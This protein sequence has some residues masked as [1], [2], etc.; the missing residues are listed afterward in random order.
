M[1]LVRGREPY[2]LQGAKERID[3]ESELMV[4]A[5]ARRVE[6]LGL[7]DRQVAQPSIIDIETPL[8]LSG[9]YGDAV[10]PENVSRAVETSLDEGETHYTV[11]PGL[12]ALARA[13]A[14]KLAR[15]QDFVVDPVAEVAITCGGREGMFIALQALTEPGR[16]V[17]VPGLR[18]AFID[19]AVRLT[20][21][22]PVPVP[23]LAQE[24]LELHA[25]RIRECLTDD[26]QLLVV[27]NPSDPTGTVIPA[28]KLAHIAALAQ[29]RDLVIISDE[30]LDESLAGDVR[31][32]SI[33]SFP[34]S[35]RRT[36]V[37]GS[38]SRLHSL[39]SW[40][41][42]YLA[43]PKS[44][45]APVRTLKLAMTLCTS[46]MAQY[47]A[48]E[49][50]AGP[51]DWLQRRRAELDAKRAFVLSA[52]EEMGLAH[53]QPVVSP[54]VLVDVRCTGRSSREFVAWLH[55]EAQVL[56]ASGDR[57]G[58]QGEGYVRLSLWPNFSKLEQAMRRIKALL[59]RTGGDVS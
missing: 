3:L 44:L 49:A 47:A 25:D 5:I 18:S 26:A 58:E 33:A 57:F 38:F 8:D 4:T 21:G 28:E 9:D 35:A 12:P 56:V 17:L 52:L 23:L 10:L 42:G 59:S 40:R 41:V 51:Q 24:G 7:T 36:V 37:V 31:H 20:G 16:E 55:S 48:L 46:A 54:Y 50:M 39:A 19:D 11:R 45:M 27:S 32:R 29:E 14:Q 34:A 13:V 43:G 15:E 30:S 22:V 2:S 53:S 6:G 1:D